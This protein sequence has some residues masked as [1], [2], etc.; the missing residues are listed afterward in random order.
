MKFKW[1]L[2]SI[3][4][5]YLL[6]ISCAPKRNVER[7]DNGSTLSTVKISELGA[8]ADGE[9]P[10]YAK[11]DLQ[12]TGVSAGAMSSKLSFMKSASVAGS[13]ADAQ[14]SRNGIDPQGSTAWCNPRNRALGL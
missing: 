6:S 14:V 10:N 4:S 13:F 12:I 8:F 1:I 9:K 5:A 11:L 3:A 7:V 2:P